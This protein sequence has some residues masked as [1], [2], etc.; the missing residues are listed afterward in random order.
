MGL[1]KDVAED[2]MH[3]PKGMKS[4]NGGAA[5]LG[6]VVV[7]TG[8]GSTVTRK[9]TTVDVEGSVI[10]RHAQ[11]TVF[12]NDVPGTAIPAPADAT[13][14]TAADY[15]IM[16]A[17]FFLDP[18]KVIDPQVVIGG[19]TV[20]QVAL[21][22]IVPVNGFY[23]LASSYVV[24]SD[25]AN[26]IIGYKLCVNGIVSDGPGRLRHKVSNASD[27]DSATFSGTTYL[28]AGDEICASLATD[29]ACTLTVSEVVRSITMMEEITL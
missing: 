16:T 22:F 1:H 7:S 12:G 5:D 10:R 13:L 6:K 17:A 8:T 21:S 19:F 23:L 4:L 24:A 11:I 29:K 14:K 28:L 27:I 26:T 3:E 15:T 9:L 20:D 18:A 25:T 2:N